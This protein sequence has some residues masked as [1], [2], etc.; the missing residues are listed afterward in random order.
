M[1]TVWTVW[2]VWIVI[3]YILNTERQKRNVILLQIC[4]YNLT[5]KSDY[6]LST[7]HKVFQ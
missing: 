5:M 1:W 4:P 7:L 2:I 3:S 6:P